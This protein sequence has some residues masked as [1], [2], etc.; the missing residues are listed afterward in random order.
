MQKTTKHGCE[1]MGIGG[2]AGMDSASPCAWLVN[3]LATTFSAPK[4]IGFVFLVPRFCLTSKV[5]YWNLHSR[6]KQNTV[7]IKF[8]KVN[9]GKPC[10]L[11]IWR[12]RVRQF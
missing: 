5:R 12:S 10:S 8:I 7:L 1:A 11:Y 9:V 2:K 3:R 6:K 4:S